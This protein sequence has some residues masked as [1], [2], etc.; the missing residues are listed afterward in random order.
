MQPSS[1]LSGDSHPAELRDW[2]ASS[3]AA[4]P[5]DSAQRASDGAAI[6]K[7]PRKFGSFEQLDGSAA[8]PARFEIADQ[9]SRLLLLHLVI[10]NA[11]LY[12]LLK[13]HS[14]DIIHMT[15]NPILGSA[16][17]ASETRLM[18]AE[19]KQHSRLLSEPVEADRKMLCRTCC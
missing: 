15:L 11:L 9:V 19:E 3:P 12:Q 5:R 13:R 17:R 6:Q 8:V 1:I 4:K 14:H 10:A 18:N 2:A 7:L 16:L